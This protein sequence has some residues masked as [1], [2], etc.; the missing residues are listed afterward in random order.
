MG[1]LQLDNKRD[2]PAAT[3]PTKLG[4]L[5]AAQETA[6]AEAEANAVAWTAQAESEA[7][8][9]GKA[10]A[11]APAPPAAGYTCAGGR[12]YRRRGN[13]TACPQ[14]LCND[15]SFSLRT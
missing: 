1:E 4:E 14:L 7:P 5:A 11:A 2:D 12:A 15:V 8:A 10:V 3:V 6:E 9:R 13:F